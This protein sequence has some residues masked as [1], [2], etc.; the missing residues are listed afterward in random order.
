MRR[1]ETF[2]QLF[3][4]YTPPPQK[5]TSSL[6]YPPGQA[7]TTEPLRAMAYCTRLATPF[8]PPLGYRTHQEGRCRVE[9]VGEG[10]QGGR[11]P[12]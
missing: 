10:A 7:H 11:F 3:V 5:K 2:S 9:H 1:G 6:P 8:P 4:P 12:D